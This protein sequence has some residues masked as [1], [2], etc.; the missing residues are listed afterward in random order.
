MSSVVVGIVIAVLLS[1]A[2]YGLQYF[3][4]TLSKGRTALLWLL[5]SGFS[6]ALVRWLSP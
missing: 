3:G 5:I 6:A 4:V 1:A 2:H